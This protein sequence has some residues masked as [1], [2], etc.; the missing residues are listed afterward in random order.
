MLYYCFIES[1]CEN[2]QK[3]NLNLVTKSM[4]Q[5]M[6]TNHHHE[7]VETIANSKQNHDY[8]LYMYVISNTTVLSM[9]LLT[10]KL[11]KNYKQK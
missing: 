11:I 10:F 3:T 1:M 4:S 5:I 8:L 9:L 2:H 7:E 6:E